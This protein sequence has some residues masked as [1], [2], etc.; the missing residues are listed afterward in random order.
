MEVGT[1]DILYKLAREFG[2]GRD[3]MVDRLKLQKT[4]YLLQAWGLPLGYGFGWYIYGPYSQELVY[5]AYRV[6]TM[7]KDEYE[8]S[9]IEWRFSDNT[10][11]WLDRFRQVLGGV[12]GDPKRL[13]LVASVDF[14]R[15]TWYPQ[16]RRGEIAKLFRKHKKVFYDRE[17]IEDSQIEEAFE[18]CE[19]LRQ[20]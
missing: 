5:D 8:K 3:S 19:R 7:E 15:T 17:Q 2:L 1:K 14:V 11:Q 10:K 9:T 20:N 6:M 13:E 16:A 4:I 18:V 12:L